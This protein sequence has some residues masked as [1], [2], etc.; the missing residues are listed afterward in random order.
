[1]RLAI[2]FVFM[3][4]QGLMLAQQAPPR[5]VSEIESLAKQYAAEHDIP[6]INMGVVL[7]GQ[8]HFINYG[9]AKRTDNLQTS[10]NSI[11]QIASVGKVLTGMVVNDL[12][13]E[14]KLDVNASILT[15]LPETYSKKTKSKLEHI[16]VRD[17]LHH[18]SGLPRQSKVIKRKNDEPII[19]DYTASDFEEDFEKMKLEGDEAF[20]Y[21][22]FGYAVLGYIAEWVSGVSF[23]EQL[24]ALAQKYGMESTSVACKNRSLLVTP[25]NE[26]DRAL[27][28]QNWEMGKLAPPSGLYSSVSDLTNL[29][30]AQIEV[31]SGD[32]Q[33]NRLYLTNDTREAW[34]GTGISYGYGLFDW[35]NGGFGHGGGMDGYGS[36]YWFHPKGRVGFVLLT[37]SGGKWVTEL[38]KEIN[39][40]LLNADTE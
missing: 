11:F 22:N 24:S 23:E 32:D 10:E 3:S 18:R 33:N 28:T 39:K 13:Q 27:E 29:L 35:G 38:S 17:L 15:Y 2:L 14:G 12:V 21:S 9:V 19:Y 8:V 6:A 36:E 7:D 5:V 40:M 34:G 16:T 20:R 4:L 37:S 31:Y 1:M 26:D 30:E 25:Y